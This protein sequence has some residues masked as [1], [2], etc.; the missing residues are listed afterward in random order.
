MKA[1]IIS[2]VFFLT[3]G[4]SS[5]ACGL[6]VTNIDS[7]TIPNVFTP[8]NDGINDVFAVT[9]LSKGDEVRIYDR[10]GS[11]VYE[12]I[13]LDDAWDGHNTSGILCSEGVYFYVVFS[14]GVH[15]SGTLQLLK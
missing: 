8:N 7:V 14:N 2:S 1:L 15:K 5:M 12:F 13:G 4:F 6:A 10:W 9:G 3:A 11:I